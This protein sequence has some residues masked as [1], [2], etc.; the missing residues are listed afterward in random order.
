MECTY[1]KSDKDET[2]PFTEGSSF[3]EQDKNGPTGR[4]VIWDSPFNA[5]EDKQ[6]KTPP[7]V[8]RVAGD[9]AY[10]CDF[11]GK[12]DTW[13]FQISGRP[14]RKGTSLMFCNEC[15]GHCL[16]AWIHS[17]LMLKKERMKHG[18]TGYLGSLFNNDR[19][20]GGYKLDSEDHVG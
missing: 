5:P 19:K 17:Y 1:P 10:A 20:G 12:L 2:L 9:Y 8:S 16:T 13:M 18:I 4:I 7:D 14:A 6:D 11:C 3:I 15:E